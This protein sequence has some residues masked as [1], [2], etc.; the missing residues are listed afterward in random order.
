MESASV[1]IYLSNKMQKL[2]LKYDDVTNVIIS[3]CT[4]IPVKNTAT[5]NED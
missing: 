5:L 2:G 4:K 3:S 1:N